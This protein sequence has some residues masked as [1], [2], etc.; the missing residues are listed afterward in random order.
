MNDNAPEVETEETSVQ[1]NT[2]PATEEVKVKGPTKN[3]LKK[4]VRDIVDSIEPADGET[5][6]FRDRVST[7]EDEET[8]DLVGFVVLHNTTEEP[9]VQRLLEAAEGKFNVYCEEWTE[10]SKRGKWEKRA[11]NGGTPKKRV[12]ST[13]GGKFV[14]ADPSIY[15]EDGTVKNPRREGTH[16]YEAF[17]VLLAHIDEHGKDVGMKYEDY[18]EKGGASNHMKWDIEHAFV[19]LGDAADQRPAAVAKPA[20]EPV[21][22]KTAEETS[23]EAAA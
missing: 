5:P 1:E 7:E 8:K 21:E 18:L 11:A 10:E 19:V 9:I 20:A 15:A 23:E 2:T 3:E 16:G 6:L 12:S 22:E 4:E 17:K 13:F 14:F